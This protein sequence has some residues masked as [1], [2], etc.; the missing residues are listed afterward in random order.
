MKIQDSFTV[1]CWFMLSCYDNCWSVLILHLSSL[2]RLGNLDMSN[3]SM[4]HY[5]YHHIRL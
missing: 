1:T 2:Q 5:S 4:I 3:H